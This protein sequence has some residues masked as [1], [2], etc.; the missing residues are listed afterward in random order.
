MIRALPV[1]LVYLRSVLSAS[2]MAGFLT[3]LLHA[4]LFL[5]HVWHKTFIILWII[6]RVSVIEDGL[7]ALRLTRS[8]Y[9]AAPPGQWKLQHPTA[10]RCYTSSSAAPPAQSRTRQTSLKHQTPPSQLIDCMGCKE[11]LREERL[12]PDLVPYTEWLWQLLGVVLCRWRQARPADAW[13]ELCGEQCPPRSISHWALPKQN[14]KQQRIEFNWRRYVWKR[15]TEILAR[16]I[17]TNPS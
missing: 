15:G 4:A 13:H 5:K 14:R 2:E 16:N 10:E 8:P 12:M 3:A 6:L 7:C 9:W 1:L 11:I 17:Q